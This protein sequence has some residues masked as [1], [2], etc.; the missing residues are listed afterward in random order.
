MKKLI[1]ASEMFL[2]KCKWTDLAMLK[3]CL[4]ASGIMIGTHVPKKVK[5]PLFF[6]SA[7]V[8]ITTYVALMHKFLPI[9]F[10]ADREKA[11]D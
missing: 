9:L 6:G 10:S 7:I 4:C 11:D 3:S 2:R 5:K 1:I 8:F